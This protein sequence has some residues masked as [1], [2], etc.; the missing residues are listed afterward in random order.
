VPSAN[1]HAVLF[2][3]SD[4]NWKLADFGLTT[5]G[6]SKALNSTRHANGTTGYRAPELLRELPAYNNKV[7]IFALGCVLFELVAGGKKAFRNDFIVHDKSK[8]LSAIDIVFV[9]VDERWHHQLQVEICRML[10]WVSE[11]RPS[12]ATIRRQFATNRCIC[13]AEAIKKAHGSAQ[14]LKVY[15]M[16][17]DVDT[18]DV[19]IEAAVWTD[20]GFAALEQKRYSLAIMAFQRA[21]DDRPNEWYSET[22]VLLASRCSDDTINGFANVWDQIGPRGCLHWFT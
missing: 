7:D 11:D 8:S 19:S 9:E 1:F 21:F 20:V 17:I 10:S 12:A 18:E 6:T 15:E 5:D 16:A 2:S 4:L 22:F 13:I 14:S 3:L